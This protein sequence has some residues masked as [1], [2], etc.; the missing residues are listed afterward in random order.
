MET[1]FPAQGLLSFS[2]RHKSSQFT[3][4]AVAGPGL[5]VFVDTTVADVRF[6]AGNLA[7]VHVGLNANTGIG[8]RNGNLEAHILGFGGKIGADGIEANT[9]IGGVNACVLM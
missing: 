2:C 8:A 6:S 9:P 3:A 4:Q 1:V 7:G 5:G